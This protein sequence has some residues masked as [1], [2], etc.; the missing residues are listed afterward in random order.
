MSNIRRANPHTECSNKN[1]AKS[2]PRPQKVSAGRRIASAPHPATPRVMEFIDNCS[3]CHGAH[4]KYE[5]RK[6]FD[7]LYNLLIQQKIEKLHA[8]KLAMQ[9]KTTEI[10]KRKPKQP[11]KPAALVIEEENKVVMVEEEINRFKF[12]EVD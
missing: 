1:R 10:A 7:L 11:E 9:V 12:I 2:R 8:D 3:V 4:Y 6:C 5:T